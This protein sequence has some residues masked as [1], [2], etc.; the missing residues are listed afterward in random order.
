VSAIRVTQSRENSAADASVPRRGDKSSG[1]VVRLSSLI[2]IPSGVAL[3]WPLNV[4]FFLWGTG[5][6]KQRLNDRK[7]SPS[8]TIHSPQSPQQSPTRTNTSPPS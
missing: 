8:P 5:L 7:V 4:F 3:A 6:E 1:F 2:P